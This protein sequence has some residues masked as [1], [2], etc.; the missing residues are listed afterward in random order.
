MEIFRDRVDLA[1]QVAAWRADGLLIGLVPTM[2]NLHE[3]HLSLVRQMAEKADRVI[4]TIYVNPLQFSKGEDFEHY[5]RTEGADLAALRALGLCDAVYMPSNVFEDSQG[6]RIRPGRVALGLESASRPHF[7]EGVASVVFK[8]FQHVKPDMAIFGEKDFQQLLVIK[9][10]VLEFELGI[11]ICSGAIV[12]A[13]N[14]LAL[15]SR[16]GYLSDVSRETGSEL[17]RCLCKT[18]ELIRETGHDGRESVQICLERGRDHLIR[19]GFGVDYFGY[20]DAETLAEREFYSAHGI[21]LAAVRLDS[22]RLLD[23]MRV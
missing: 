20:F 19:V 2:G 6:L 21:I 3:G 15:S 16:N 13:E 14:G 10:L 7:F 4:T 23:N 1:R 22:V 11:E 9:D 5:P 18:A 8:L 17:Y 12:R